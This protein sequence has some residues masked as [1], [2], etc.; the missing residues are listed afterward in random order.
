[1]SVS[2]ADVFVLLVTNIYR[3]VRHMYLPNV[4]A[5]RSF[6]TCLPLAGDMYPSRTL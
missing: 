2:D 4:Q 6:D 5:T 3:K 1:M